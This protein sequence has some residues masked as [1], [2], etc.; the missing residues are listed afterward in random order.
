MS[1]LPIMEN[2]L[3]ADFIIIHLNKSLQLIFNELNPDELQQLKGG[4]AKRDAN[5]LVF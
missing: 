1:V 3:I 5:P 2:K 4:S